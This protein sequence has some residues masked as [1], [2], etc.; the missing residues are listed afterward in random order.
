MTSPDVFER[1]VE[2]GVAQPGDSD[3][4]HHDAVSGHRAAPA[5]AM[6][7]GITVTDDWDRY[8]TRHVVFTPKPDD[9]RATRSRLLAR[10][11][12]FLPV[13]APSARG[14]PAS[15]RFP[16]GTPPRLRGRLE[17]TRAVLG[18]RHPR[19][20]GQRRCSPCWSGRS[21]HSPV[22]GRCSPDLTPQVRAARSPYAP[23]SARRGTTDRRRVLGH[24]DAG[25][26][27]PVQRLAQQR[28]A[29][30]CR[31]TSCQRRRRPGA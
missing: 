30:R 26:Q 19:A 16:D 12:R 3:V 2:W 31:G 15:R 5:S 7:A 9:P 8:D 20:P 4:P 1:T 18:P 17:E 25:E 22:P 10:V 28:R 24:T 11:P 23:R 27:Q 13:V 21:T 29:S 6:R 14:P